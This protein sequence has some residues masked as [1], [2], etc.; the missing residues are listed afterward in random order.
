MS[1]SPKAIKIHNPFKVFILTTV[2]ISA[3]G[4]IDYIT[5]EI[6]IDLLYILCV[7]IVRWHT[8]TYLGIICVF[9]IIIAKVAAD[10]FDQIKIGS[11][12]YEWNMFSNL[13]MY[14]IVCLLIGNLRKVL[15]K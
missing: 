11:H 9:E 10:Y 14:L 6:S 13:C 2:F 7:S 1:D 5:G 3:L 4:Y 8:N 12:F 15:S